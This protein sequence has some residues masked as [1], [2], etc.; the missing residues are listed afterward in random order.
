MGNV[1]VMAMGN[2]TFRN[3]LIL[4]MPGYNKNKTLTLELG[5]PKWSLNRVVSH[6]LMRPVVKPTQLIKSEDHKLLVT[7]ISR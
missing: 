6:E 7:L 3:P 5:V 2:M 4:P 1:T